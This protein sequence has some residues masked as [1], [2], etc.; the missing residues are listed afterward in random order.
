[1]KELINEATLFFKQ[2]NMTIKNFNNLPRGKYLNKH[3]V[4]IILHWSESKL[5]S[6]K[7]SL[8]KQ[9]LIK[10]GQMNLKNN[11]IKSYLIEGYHYY[12]DGGDTLYNKKRIMEIVENSQAILMPN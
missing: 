2:L 8:K 3:Q 4:M 9:Q 12:I 5:K 1:M 7:L 6:R 11:D 10:D